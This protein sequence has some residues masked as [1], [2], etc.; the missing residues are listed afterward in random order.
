VD[1]GTGNRSF[2]F[3]SPVALG[4][5][6]VALLGALPF[7]L[8]T[9]FT[10]D[11]HLFLAF[12]RNVANPLV[13]FTTDMHGGEFYRPLPM[14][15]WW[16]IGRGGGF[17]RWPFALFAYVLHLLVSL[18][19][20]GLVAR[21]ARDRRVAV[22]AGTFFFVAPFTRE[23][24]YWYSASTDLL[25]VA[26]GLGALLAAVNGGAVRANLLLLG[27]CLSKES[28]AVVPALTALA[29]WARG[30]ELGWKAALRSGARMIPAV[31]LVL[32]ART[33]V[34]RGFGGSGDVAA[35]V[36]GK[37]AQLTFGLARALPG[38][39][40]FSPGLATI[41]G[42][43]AWLAL[44]IVVGVHA[45]RSG[46]ATVPVAP[47]VWM[48][49]SVLPLLA[50]P[51]IVGARYFYLAAVGV[52]WL[53]AQVLSRAPHWAT[54][55]V[56]AGLGGVSFAQAAARLADVR[57]YEARVATTRRAI[58]AGVAAGH[59]TFHVAG[60]IKDIDLAVKEDPRL[61]G[62]AQ[63]ELVVLGDVPASFVSL[64]AAQPSR[65]D[66]LLAHPPLPPSGAYLFGSKRIAG[67][68]RRGDDPT[69]DE[70]MARLPD[71]RFIRLRMA[72]GGRIIYRD[73]TDTLKAPADETE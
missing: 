53:W 24:A 11:D 15:L 13:V 44:M 17:A 8:A 42:L 59:R 26:L 3:A 19:T 57:S 27:A 68:A 20:G 30:P 48:A 18:E 1:A 6:G 49:L 23:A 36:S 29:V 62:P 56:L 60:G 21:M 7:F 72:P 43:T 25:A 5:V 37:L 39:D 66:F 33:V 50:A 28:A 73:V 45:R 65:I 32:V 47:L 55:V 14:L 51:W 63:D 70:V 41:V 40:V 46:R 64:P 58:L 61:S 69:L 2:A 54:V 67:L 35:T 34:L 22:V 9:T 16:L 12:A 71:L 52:A 31:A 10:G 38:E 4:A